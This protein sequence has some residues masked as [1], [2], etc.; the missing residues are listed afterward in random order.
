MRVYHGRRLWTPHA[1]VRAP[2]IDYQVARGK[3]V[4]EAQA[5]AQG[6]MGP[7]TD[8][9]NKTVLALALRNA[10]TSGIWSP[11]VSTSTDR[12]V[13]LS[14]ALADGKAGYCLTIEGPADRFYDFN[15]VRQTNG[16]PHEPVF[17]W[18][19]ELGIALE[20]QDPFRVLRADLV[21][22]RNEVG[23]CVYP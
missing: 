21:T 9:T 4:L 8:F 23:T 13:A 12:Q 2:S 18:L 10:Q 15:E 14:F 6:L 20:V 5:Y 11:F 1:P 7:L 3:S 19:N 22:A 17:H 16:I